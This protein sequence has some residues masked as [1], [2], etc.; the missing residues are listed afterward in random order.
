MPSDEAIVAANE[1]RDDPSQTGSGETQA[2][3]EI[4]NRA[5]KSRVTFSLPNRETKSDGGSTDQSTIGEMP[6]SFETTFNPHYAGRGSTESQ[7][8]S[9]AI[10]K[11]LILAMYS[12]ILFWAGAW[13]VLSLDPAAIQKF[14]YKQ[15]NEHHARDVCYVFVGHVLVIVSGTLY[16]Q[17]SILGTY[18]PENVGSTPKLILQVLGGIGIP[19]LWVGM[20]KCLFHHTFLDTGN[21]WYTGEARSAGSY[22]KD[23]ILF[24][25]GLLGLFCTGLFYSVAMVFPTDWR[26]ILNSSTDNSGQRLRTCLKALICL[27]SQGCLLVASVS[28]CAQ[29]RAWWWRIVLWGMGC[30]LLCVTPGLRH[31]AVLQSNRFPDWLVGL[32]ALFGA[33]FHNCGCWAV[34]EYWSIYN[35]QKDNAT[36]RLVQ[37]IIDLSLIGF[38]VGGL[39]LCGNLRE[40]FCL[41]P[42]VGGRLRPTQSLART[43][44]RRHTQLNMFSSS[45]S[46]LSTTS[47]V[48]TTTWV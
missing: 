37:I 48:S 21:A 13:N 36:Y 32:A 7:A 35:Q 15:M 5:T 20:F 27:W 30:C 6:F 9:S 2:T 17:A 14:Q 23:F 40:G 39:H 45:R 47:M 26:E 22:W 3:P 31:P 12:T 10:S 44:A 43:F 11:E 4:P 29:T 18:L 42:I 28:I 24:I 25:L 41:S 33:L 16:S 8:T 46:V 38:G 19:L 34:L 1:H